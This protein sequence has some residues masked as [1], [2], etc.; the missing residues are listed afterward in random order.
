VSSYATLVW[1]LEAITFRI[2]KVIIEFTM[3]HAFFIAGVVVNSD[4]DM[5]PS[6]HPSLF[7]DN[8]AIVTALLQRSYSFRQL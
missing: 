3:F 1:S 7:L 2:H 6:M 4:L 8:K 5:L